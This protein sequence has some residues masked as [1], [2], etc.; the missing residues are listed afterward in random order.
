MEPFA[1]IIRTNPNIHGLWVGPLEDKLPLY[2]DDALQ[3]LNDPQSSPDGKKKKNLF[4]LDKRAPQA[5][6]T[7]FLQWVQHFKYIGI[8][9]S[10][11]P[12]SFLD[13]MLHL[14]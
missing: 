8:H 2:A 4:P 9:V 3:Y 14:S 1:S 12:S 10:L 13:L 7:T 6:S 11:E 5:A